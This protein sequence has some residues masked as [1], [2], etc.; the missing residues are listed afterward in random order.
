VHI[1][2]RAG[3]DVTKAYPELVSQAEPL[4]DVLLDGEIVA[5][6][7]GRPS[8]ELLQRRMHV[9]GTGE[10][11][12]LAREIPVTYVVF[13]MLRRY[14]VDLTARPYRERRATLERWAAEN[15]GWT[16]SPSFDDGDATEAAA[17]EHGL[18]GVIAKRLDSPYRA[19]GRTAEWV[20]L[21]FRTTASFV[22]IGWESAATRPEVL[23]SLILGC[24]ADGVLT[25]AGKAG[26]GL[27]S[28]LSTQ[29]RSMLVD[30]M[31]SP[32]AETVPVPAGRVVHWSE[33]TV[34]V[35]VEFTQRTE[36]GRLRQ[37]VFRG[38]RDDVRA[39]EATGH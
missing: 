14:G 11:R 19:G 26:S 23:S 18:E 9:R 6:A 16:I 35:D 3:N 4:E 27:T 36:D 32:V 34:V 24:Y 5:I 13:D 28:V 38:V 8:F 20:K 29:L 22:V 21:R 7:D 39:D 25:Y 2:S 37:P 15:A 10:A 31:S 12:R 17:R 1:A 30:R 33:P